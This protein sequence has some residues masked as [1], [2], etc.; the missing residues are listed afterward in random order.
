MKVPYAY[1][2]CGYIVPFHFECS[3]WCWCL[4]TCYFEELVPEPSYYDAVC[5]RTRARS[6]KICLS[7]RLT[8][9]FL[10]LRQPTVRHTH[11]SRTQVFSVVVN[12]T[13]HHC[14][15]DECYFYLFTKNEKN[16]DKHARKTSPKNKLSR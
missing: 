10:P 12:H 5:G 2:W 16:E 6:D 4:L 13:P 3:R 14:N 15:V 11:V 8:H 7:H 9:P 1:A